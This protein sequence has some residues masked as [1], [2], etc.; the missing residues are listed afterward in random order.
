MKALG[1][2]SALL[3]TVG[4]ALADG[5]PMWAN[6]RAITPDDDWRHIAA[7]Y[8]L[9]F[10]SFSP[11]A[12]GRDISS[13]N[14]RVKWIKSLNPNMTVLVYGSV[15]KIRIPAPPDKINRMSAERRFL[16]DSGGPLNMAPCSNTQYL[17]G[18]CCGVPVATTKDTDPVNR[19][20]IQEKLQ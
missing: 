7:R 10:T 17:L 9:V 1:W 4:T 20:E 5:I 18:Y 16:A 8:S 12:Y 14:E 11:T 3:C 2:I 6:V 13:E 19:N 15:L